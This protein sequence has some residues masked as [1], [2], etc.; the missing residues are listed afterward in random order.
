[1]GAMAK[2]AI[3]ITA[4][5]TAAVIVRMLIDKRRAGSADLN[6]NAIEPMRRREPTAEASAMINPIILLRR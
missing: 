3:G 2:K 4:T 6:D 5:A 1:M